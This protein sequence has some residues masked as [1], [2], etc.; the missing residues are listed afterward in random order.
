MSL[1]HNANTFFF[2]AGKGFKQSFRDRILMF[3]SFLTY[4]A[5]MLLYAGVIKNIPAADLARFSFGA[6]DMIWY[7]GTAEFMVFMTPSWC[8]KEL[9]NDIVLGQI[10]LAALRPISPAL[11]RIGTWAGEAAA[12]AVVL[13]FPYLAL[14]AVLTGTFPFSVFS[15]LG[16]LA[17]LPLAILLIVCG[18]YFVGA[19]CFWFIQSEPAFWVWQ[20]CMFLLGAMLWPLSFYPAWLQTVSWASPFPAMV[21]IGARWT[22]AGP[23]A[24]YAFAFLHQIVWVFVFLAFLRFYERKIL[25]HIQET[26]A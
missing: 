7:L 26:G 6:A 10:H 4:G 19:T 22:L 15:M 12:R 23:W 1:C 18:W 5:I 14:M 3:G 20:K 8:F 2:C 24:V 25:R 21:S 16:L 9:Q 17:S 13:F 11:I